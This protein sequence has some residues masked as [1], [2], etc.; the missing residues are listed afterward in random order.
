MAIGF[1][2]GLI[3]WFRKKVNYENRFSGL[4]RENAFGIYFFHAPILVAVSLALRGLTLIP[5]LKFIVVTIITFI[6]CLVFS[7]LVRKIKPVGILLK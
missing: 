6:I 2:L 7:F 5:F 3:A 1:S 4:M